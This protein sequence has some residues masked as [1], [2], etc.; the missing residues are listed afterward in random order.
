MEEETVSVGHNDYDEGLMKLEK[1]SSD[2][3]LKIKEEAV[4]LVYL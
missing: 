3:E 1:G 4:E 2:D